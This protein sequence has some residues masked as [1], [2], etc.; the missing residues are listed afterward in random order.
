MNKASNKIIKLKEN[1]KIF[2]EDMSKPFS[3]D[4]IEPHIDKL[5]LMIKFKE[6]L[7]TKRYSVN[8]VREL[9]NLYQKVI[10]IL[11]AK[12]DPSFTIYLEKLHL[13]LQS[14]NASPLDVYNVEKENKE[15]N[16]KSNH[17]SQN[18]NPSQ[19]RESNYKPRKSYKMSNNTFSTLN[20]NVEGGDDD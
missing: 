18:Q 8:I 2:Q 4:D 10:E 11:S 7:L 19:Q 14:K 12:N 16:G 5:Q 1:F 17:S 13:M 20:A 6:D 9:M 15:E 3:D